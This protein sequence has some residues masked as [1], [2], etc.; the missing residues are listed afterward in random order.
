MLEK[1]YVNRFEET[2]VVTNL[3][4]VNHSFTKIVIFGGRY[5]SFIA[6]ICMKAF[7]GIMH[8]L[9]CTPHNTKPSKFPNY[10]MH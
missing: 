8:E 6:I 7:L 9:V 5:R 2:P 4:K 3:F 1:I 10:V